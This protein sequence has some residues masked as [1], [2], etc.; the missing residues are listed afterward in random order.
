ML[1]KAAELA[2]L[3]G[4]RRIADEHIRGAW[5]DLRKLKKA[6]LISKLNRDQRLLLK[7]IES[8]P[9]IESGELYARYVDAASRLGHRS[10]ARRIFRKYIRKMLELGIIKAVQGRMRARFFECCE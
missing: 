6:Y 1:R 5:K 8:D 4:K 9:R 10:M 7:I 3:D 2:E